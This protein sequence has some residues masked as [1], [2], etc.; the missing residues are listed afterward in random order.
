MQ[1][2][3]ENRRRGLSQAL[4]VLDALVLIRRSVAYGVTA[5]SL[6]TRLTPGAAAAARPGIRRSANVCTEARRCTV[7]SV[8]ATVIDRAS[9]SAILP[10]A[11]RTR[12]SRSGVA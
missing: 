7:S 2:P 6:A 4:R 1:A 5:R 3:T 10:I 8:A 9:R 12:S 11:S